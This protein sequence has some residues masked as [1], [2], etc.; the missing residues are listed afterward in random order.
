MAARFVMRRSD[1]LTSRD[2]ASKP[3]PD[4][5]TASVTAQIVMLVDRPERDVCERAACDLQFARILCQDCRRNRMT[6]GM[7]ADR[8]A[9]QLDTDRAKQVGHRAVLKRLTLV[10]D[11]DSIRGV[12]AKEAR[13]VLAEVCQQVR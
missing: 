2:V 7:A 13:P 1:L 12:S 4:F 10:V 9:Q 3:L 5:A 6:K 8:K 11:P